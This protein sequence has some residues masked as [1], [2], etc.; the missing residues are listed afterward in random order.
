MLENNEHPYLRQLR[1]NR[2][3]RRRIEYAKAVLE[4][5]VIDAAKLSETGAISVQ[6]NVAEGMLGEL[7]THGSIE[8]QLPDPATLSPEELEHLRALGYVQ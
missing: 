5:M 6:M 7:Q 4:S 2:L 1:I 8:A 3:N